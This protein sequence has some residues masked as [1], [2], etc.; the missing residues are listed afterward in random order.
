MINHTVSGI[1]FD[2]HALKPAK[3]QHIIL[4]G[5]SIPCDYQII[6]H[7]DGDV[8]LH[9]IVDAILGTIAAG[10]IGEHFPPSDARWK[11]ADS[12]LFLKHTLQLCAEKKATLIHLDVTIIAEVPKINPYKKIMKEKLS[13][14]T[15]LAL[16]HINIKATTTEQLGFLGRKE[17]IAAQAIATIYYEFTG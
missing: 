4:C 3:N 13:E 1:G 8:A 11:N 15:G 6:A 14:I 2:V 16:H 10:D 9:A 7:S 5:V 12:T 17:G